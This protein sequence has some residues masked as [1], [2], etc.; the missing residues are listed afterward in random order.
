MEKTWIGTIERL[1]KQDIEMSRDS[2]DK[3][4]LVM[5]SLSDKRDI[6]GR[7]KKIDDY[8]EN[9]RWA[10]WHRSHISAYESILNMVEKAKEEYYDLD[11]RFRDL[12][13][14]Y[15]KLEEEYKE[16][17]NEYN[18]LKRYKLK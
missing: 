17:E 2:A 5:K 18:V 13:T 11:A 10:Y 16:L 3:C 4:E 9:H 6:F 12:E 15:A 8:E 14:K 1:M 7:I